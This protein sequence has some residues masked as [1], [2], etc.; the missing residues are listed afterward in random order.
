VA[1]THIWSYVY[2][3]WLYK[4][5]INLLYVLNSKFFMNN[6]NLILKNCYAEFFFLRKLKRKGKK[7]KLNGEKYSR[8]KGVSIASFLIRLWTPSRGETWVTTHEPDIWGIKMTL[9]FFLKKSFVLRLLINIFP[10]SIAF[11]VK[12]NHVILEVTFFFFQK[13]LEVTLRRVIKLV[14]IYWSTYP[15]KIIL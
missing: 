4:L 8:R 1:K 11:Y 15:K 6:S 10:S 9:F 12:K 13:T 5:S 3:C 2:F 7:T 14:S